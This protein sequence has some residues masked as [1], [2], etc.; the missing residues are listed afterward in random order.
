M[1]IE[2]GDLMALGVYDEHNLTVHKLSPEE[3]LQ[4]KPP[5]INYDEDN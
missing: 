1:G 2:R 3:L 5:T 4:I